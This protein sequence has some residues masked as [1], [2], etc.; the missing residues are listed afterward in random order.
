MKA[1][2]P[3]NPLGLGSDV[4]LGMSLLSLCLKTR[5]TQNLLGLGLCKILNYIPSEPPSEG[6]AALSFLGLGDCFL[7]WLGP[8][9]VL[10]LFRSVNF[11]PPEV[12]LVSK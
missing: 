11:P 3:Q 2:L 1:R 6:S 7:T 12:I 8:W 5:P 9:F 10:E 4:F